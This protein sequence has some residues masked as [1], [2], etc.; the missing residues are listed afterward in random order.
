[1][2]TVLERFS[3]YA[4]SLGAASLPPEALHHARRSVLDWFAAAVAGGLEPPATLLVEALGEELGRGRAQLVPSGRRATARAAALINGAASHTIEFDDIFRDGIYHPGVVTVPAALALAQ[5]R[6]LSGDAFLRA[7]IAGYEVG[8]RIGVAVNPAHYEYWHTTATVGCFGAAAAASV[9]LGLDA[10]RAAHAM[11]TAGTMAAGL[12]QAFRA[13]CMSKPMHA[14]H[15]A[16]VGV[17]C[18]L[19]AERGLTGAL[20]ILEGER[21][22]G[23]AMCE[24]P[25]WEAALASLGKHFNIT[26][27][28]QKNHSACG[29]IHAAIDAVLALEAEHAIAPASVKR[30]VARTYR[31][32]LEIAGT[33]D[34]H[35]VFEAKFSLPYC[36]AAA[37]VVGSV[38][39]DAFSPERLADP[40]IRALLAKVEME[41]EPKL[42][43]SFPKQRGAIVEIE[44]TDGRRFE[45]F[46]PTRKGDPDAPLSDA[47]LQDKAREL[48]A[49][50]LGAVPT[51]RFLETLWTLDRVRDISTLMPE[52]A[53]DRL[54]GA[55]Q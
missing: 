37:L 10:V 27:M 24:R 21:G 52:A 20:D 35:T 39:I 1:M 23:A 38:R 11:A 32:A 16:E 28:T 13:D 12:Q 54:A 2:P 45:H 43:A 48:I 49:P 33:K 22:F 50:V 44:T 17:T 30:I 55:A 19:G 8:T 14:A 29:H 47:E 31:T 51:A 5:S 36:L 26:Q 4:V 42:D 41:V 3:S 7:V 15:A 25:D 18:A 9:A 6:G 40:A 53:G 46:A 34:P